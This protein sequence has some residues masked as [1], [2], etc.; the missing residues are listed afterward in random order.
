MRITRQRDSA[1]NL[2]GWVE[3]KR[4]PG[5]TRAAGEVALMFGGA[6]TDMPLTCRF[7]SGN[8]LP[9]LFPVQWHEGVALPAFS[10]GGI[11]VVFD[12]QNLKP[13]VF[14]EHV[15][16]RQLLCGQEFPSEEGRRFFVSGPST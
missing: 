1:H 4:G 9:A 6:F 3:A 14:A 12:L 10:V 2:L 5:A 11:A 13:H 15:A 7:D 8:S 16:G